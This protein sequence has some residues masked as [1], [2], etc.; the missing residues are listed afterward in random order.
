MTTR[1]TF[2]SAVFVLAAGTVLF[3]GA[4]RAEQRLAAE[5]P[6]PFYDS[7]GDLLPD[8]V[9]RMLLTS[10]A[11]V[12]SDGDTIGDFLDAVQHRQLVKSD[13]PPVPRDHELRVVIS[14][15][16]SLDGSEHI[17]INVLMRVMHHGRINQ[18]VPFLFVNNVAYPI[19]SLLGNGLVHVGYRHDP[20]EGDLVA[21][22]GRLCSPREFR[23]LLPCVVGV[24]AVIDDREL[25][26]G[27]YATLLN[28]VPVVMVPHEASSSPD[29]FVAQSL[30]PGDVPGFWATAKA[31]E[32]TLEEQGTTSSGVIC[33]IMSGACVT[34]PTLQCAPGCDRMAGR[35]LVIPSGLGTL[36]G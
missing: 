6:A 36:R 34:V 2:R 26:R 9:E 14:T 1:T 10:I 25:T 22:S 29:A 15:E 30:S 18:L 4:D 3:L 33:E 5:Q 23:L 17:V 7:D 16:T 27:S 24:R 19:G 31:C 20:V 21:Y 28:D 13:D 35:V 11:E 8:A 32:L 12:D